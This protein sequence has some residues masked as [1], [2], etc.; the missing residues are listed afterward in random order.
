[1]K[2]LKLLF[3]I[4]IILFIFSCSQT[5]TQPEAESIEKQMN[6]MNKSIQNIEQT[7]EMVDA[8]Q[9]EIEKVDKLRL[10]GKIS[11]SEANKMYDEITEIYGR[12][13]AKRSNNNPATSLPL[14]ARNLG[15]TEPNGM[16]L[17]V[18]FSQQTSVANFEEGFNSVLLVY[19]GS[20]EI[21][22][23]EAE[24]IARS[25][26]IPI[27]KEFQ[28]AVEL[29]KTYSSN[30]FK[31]IAYMNFEPFESDADINVSIT[32][33]EKGTLTISAVDMN[34]MRLQSER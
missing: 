5:A 1:M 6:S 20:Y 19:Q 4:G 34:Q 3:C 17:D 29:A 33:D 26:Q 23:R 18:D 22:M 2:P 30:P 31:G 32:V 27:S 25:A 16:R 24:R 10:D 21:A 9:R 7:M 28:Q 14:W 11:E 8:M 15:L 13:I 12:S